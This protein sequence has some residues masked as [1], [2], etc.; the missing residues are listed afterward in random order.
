MSRVQ[1]GIGPTDAVARYMIETSQKYLLENVLRPRAENLGFQ[2][3]ENPK[4]DDKFYQSFGFRGSLF[5]EMYRFKELL[6]EKKEIS[7]IP[8]IKLSVNLDGKVDS[9][10]GDKIIATF[11]Y[12]PGGY[13]QKSMDTSLKWYNKSYNWCRETVFLDNMIERFNKIKFSDKPEITNDNPNNV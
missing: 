13:D 10:G 9:F 12:A 7:K 1:S 4:D 6:N 3:A 5:F 11:H 8:K 2:N